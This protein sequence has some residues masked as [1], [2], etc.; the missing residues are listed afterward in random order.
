MRQRGSGIEGHQNLSLRKRRGYGGSGLT[1]SSSRLTNGW[2]V[3][4]ADLQTE[5]T[6]LERLRCKCDLC[7]FLKSIYLYQPA[8]LTI[9]RLLNMGLPLFPAISIARSPS[10]QSLPVFSLPPRYSFTIS[11][12]SLTLCLSLH[13]H[14]LCPCSAIMPPPP[15][16]VCL[17]PLLITSFLSVRILIFPRLSIS[18]SL[19]LR[20]RCRLVVSEN[21]P[22]TVRLQIQSPRQTACTSTAMCPVKMSL[23]KI[24]EYTPAQSFSSFF[25]SKNNL[26]IYFFLLYNL[27]LLSLR[28]Y[29]LGA[30]V[31][32]WPPLVVSAVI[33]LHLCLGW[34][35]QTFRAILMIIS[36]V[37]YSALIF[38]TEP[39][40]VWCITSQQMAE[41][42]SEKHTRKTVTTQG[43]ACC[44]S[45]WRVT[46]W[47]DY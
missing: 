19:F 15:P 11:S 36:I 8:F 9:F 37:V 29:S 21:H 25:Q 18:L 39:D 22:I 24:A 5:E 32:L 1:T 23:G 13:H 43:Y 27:I 20:W 30:L 16:S 35:T 14:C 42:V 47:H 40:I 46:V 4:R 17:F 3:F 7:L 26:F 31:W 41:D 2:W 38:L 33:T 6:T 34:Y 28:L 44:I 10:S 45:S 12:P